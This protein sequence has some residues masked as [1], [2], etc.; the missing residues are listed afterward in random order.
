M[1][2]YALLSLEIILLVVFVSLVPILFL[3]EDATKIVWT[4]V[5]P[6]VPIFFV[7]IGYSNWRNICPLAFFSKL[8][9]KIN[10][11]PKRK[12]PVWL[13]DNFYFFQYF[14]LFSS[15]SARLVILNFD[16]TSLAF[17]FIYIIIFAFTINLI[18]TG[19]SWCNFFCPVGVVEKIYCG[20]NAKN[21]TNNSACGTCT[22]CKKNCPDI[23]ME[24]N[25]WKEK[26][27]NQKTFVFYSFSGLVLGF[28]T[29]FY[30]YAG[31]T[32]FYFSGEW[33]SV[34]L[35]LFSAGFFFLPQVPLL[36]AAP[37]TLALF[38][39]G[40]YYVFKLLEMLMYKRE[41][42]GKQE[43]SVVQHRVRI[44]AAF[45]AFNIFYAFAGA[46][47][48]SQYPLLYGIFY[49][50][51]IF[52]STLTLNK[53]FFRREDFFIQ[54]RFALKMIKNWNFEKPIPRNLKEIYYTYANTVENKKEKIET[55]KESISELLHDGILT[56][57][58]MRILERLREQMGISKNDHEKVIRTLKLKNEKLFDESIESSTEEI[59]QKNSYKKVIEDAL[60]E[61]RELDSAQINSLRKQFHITEKIHEEIMDELLHTNDNLYKDVLSTIKEIKILRRAHKSIFNDNSREIKFLK[62]VIQSEL[63]L[64]RK[65]LFILLGVMYKDHEDD[66]NLLKQIFK[67]RIGG[68]AIDV[69][70]EVLGFMDV[71]IGDAIFELKK[72]FDS[73]KSAKSTKENEPMINYLLRF[74]SIHIASAALLASI[75]YKNDITQN[76]H[77]ERLLHSGY[78]E[79]SALAQKIIDH[80]DVVTLY[81]KMM[82][83]YSIPLFESV[84]WSHLKMLAK[85]TQLSQYPE[86][87]FIVRQGGVGDTLFMII[88]GRADV[89]RDEE[90]INEFS[91]ND[92]FGAVAL[93]GDITRTASVQTISDVRV[94]SLSKDAFKEVIYD[95]PKISLKLMKEII[96]RLTDNNKKCDLLHDAKV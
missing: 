16:S 94:L 68:S 54:E 60:S 74:D 14:V 96:H 73:T 57:N 87:E 61:H 86:G 83:L 64:L 38:S 80:K 58:S 13:E 77:F 24:S 66:L 56:Q 63:V 9:Q 92:Y 84:K 22:A 10:F 52:V 19:K 25:Y 35:G 79:A 50:I 37:L 15:F 95:N 39:V 20:S 41:L 26:N 27:N 23:D 89:I 17:F 1:G 7:I 93:L 12:V 51:V 85:A 18:F 72:S 33:S 90:I 43:I 46:P 36:F 81:E 65:D 3:F 6:L 5:V 44:I 67:D 82:Y 76:P 8:S 88:S 47:T 29:Y 70:R 48:Y 55:Y 21:Y 28:Y 62:F 59:Y 31:T 4:A 53:E 91:K 49:F 75:P 2:K 45:V 42:F 71:K 30:L 78:Q 40:S 69:E 11:F 34:E 32:E